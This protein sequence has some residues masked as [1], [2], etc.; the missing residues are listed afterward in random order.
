MIDLINSAIALLTI[1]LGLF[2][3]LAPRYTAEALDFKLADTTMGLS[4]LRASAGGLF[5][6]M[7]LACLITGA[8]G[9]YAM[10]GVAYAGAALGRL[11]SIV[12]D[13]PPLRKATLWFAF[14]ALPACW[15]L[16][17]NPGPWN[18]VVT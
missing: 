15:L 5:V 13:K 7:G 6:I 18:A 3:F 16:A 4:E 8:S 9:A 11:L 1:A 2:G 12:L 17:A 10:L 14:E